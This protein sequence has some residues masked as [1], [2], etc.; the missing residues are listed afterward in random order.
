MNLRAIRSAFTKTPR[1]LCLALFIGLR[2]QGGHAQTK[3]IHGT[4]LHQGQAII[5]A[6]VSVPNHGHK[7]TTDHQGKFSLEIP[8]NANQ[9]LI[10]A[11]GFVPKSIDISNQSEF[12]INLNKMDLNYFE[13][14][15]IE[16]LLNVNVNVVS[17][18]GE[19]IFRSPSTVS[20]IDKNMIEQYGFVSISEALNYIAGFA[21]LP[22]YFQGD[23]PTSR[24]ILQ[25][26]YANKVLILINGMPQWNAVTGATH[27]DRIHI[28]NVERI[29]V[30][31]G[32]AS[33]LY[34]SNA[35][36]GAVNIVFDSEDNEINL[37]Q[38][39]GHASIYEIGGSY[40]H[41][42]PGLKLN[43][44]GSSSTNQAKAIDW[45]DINGIPGLYYPSHKT[46]RMN[47]QLEKQKHLVQYNFF[48]KEFV[49][50]GAGPQWRF[51]AGNSH[52][53]SGHLLNY[54]YTYSYK[55]N[56]IRLNLLADW[57]STDFSRSSH[58]SLRNRWQGL[59]LIPS[60]IYSRQFNEQ[61][62]LTSGFDL[63]YRSSFEG[64]TYIKQ[65]DSIYSEV[66]LD[67]KTAWE[68]S[69]WLQFK[70]QSDKIDATIGS[71][72]TK[73]QYFGTNISSRGAFIINF[74]RQHALKLIAGQ[75]YRAPSLFELYVN[76]PINVIGNKELKP[77]INNTLEFAYLSM[78]QDL[79]F[80]VLVY[81]AS[82]KNKI[83]RVREGSDPFNY[84]NGQ[85]FNAY[86]I[87]LEAKLYVSRHIDVFIDGSYI[88]GSDA[89]NDLSDA[90][91][92]A[93]VPK[94]SYS[95]GLAGKIK[96]LGI[97]ASFAGWSKTNGPHEK[98]DQQYIL[99]GL[100]RY[101][102]KLS[103]ASIQHSLIIKN[104]LDQEIVFP[105]YAYKSG[106]L[107]EIP[108]EYGFYRQIYYTLLIKF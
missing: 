55:K 79:F 19:D 85:R 8:N 101:K 77:E 1:L 37:F 26:S 36:S 51:G 58:D 62:N 17:T 108:T 11:G 35:Y 28:K 4:V 25:N 30:L 106:S 5:N 31:R 83:G 6:Q 9:I 94:L 75:A 78:Y 42:E 64:L 74:N 59:R 45:V 16:E 12:L 46:N 60:L 39:I 91:I 22:T 20:V 103:D 50:F 65:T 57:H 47:F 86:G 93:Y 14:L 100:I 104:L 44:S 3:H 48:S 2:L 56:Q 97:S 68:Y 33:V 72:L 89:K 107:N 49:F 52:K 24:G 38:T 95:G 61:L 71:R 88:E 34:G 13:S 92:F 67:G 76:S 84:I 40:R 7:D 41:N 53:E 73:N 15:S 90:L 10:E 63:D 29:E 32:P 18:E 80:Q 21:V 98:I 43:L 99:N 102:H 81:Y 27:L 105:E 66:G 87:E 96:R 23:L 82:Y 69:Y 54:R 70:Y